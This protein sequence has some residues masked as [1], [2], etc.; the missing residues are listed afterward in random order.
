M[1]NKKNYIVYKHFNAIIIICYQ[2]LSNLININIERQL[3]NGWEKGRKMK[4]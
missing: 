2:I 3:N 1:K 4:F